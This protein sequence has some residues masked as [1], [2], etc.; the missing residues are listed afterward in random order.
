[1]IGAKHPENLPCFLFAVFYHQDDP[2]RGFVYITL[3][4]KGMQVTGLMEKK[5]TNAVLLD[6]NVFPDSKYVKHYY[7]LASSLGY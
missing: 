3:T 7:F 6:P 2:K 1:M 4:L 5:P